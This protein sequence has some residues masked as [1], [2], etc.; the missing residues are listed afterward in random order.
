M[1]EEIGSKEPSER[2]E[3]DKPFTRG[4]TGREIDRKREREER[5]KDPV[6]NHLTCT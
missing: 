6:S 3:R 2:N 1:D 5:S 4:H